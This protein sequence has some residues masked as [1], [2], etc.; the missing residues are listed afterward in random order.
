ML[1]HPRIGHFGRSH[2]DP[3]LIQESIIG[4]S[5]TTHDKQQQLK[6]SVLVRVK[7]AVFEEVEK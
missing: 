4:K 7:Q 3:S 6:K 2:P 1:G 5:L